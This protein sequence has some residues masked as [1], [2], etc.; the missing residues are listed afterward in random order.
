[1]YFLYNRISGCYMGRKFIKRDLN[2]FNQKHPKR[3]NIKYYVTF[4]KWL[5]CYA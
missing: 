1:M 2:P 3:K 4:G 5:D